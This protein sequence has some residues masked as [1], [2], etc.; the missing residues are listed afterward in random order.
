[1]SARK[2]ETAGDGFHSDGQCLFLKV[3]DGGRR[4]SWVYRFVR[5]GKAT[6]MGLGPVSAVSLKEAR[7]KRDEL[8]KMVMMGL[9]PLDE[10]RKNIEARASRKTFGDAAQAYIAQ[11]KRDWSASS[12]W[13]WTNLVTRKELS[14]FVKLPVDEIGLDDVK[15]PVMAMADGGAVSTA[16]MAQS[17]IHAVLDFAVEHGWRSEDRRSSWSPIIRRPKGERPHHP[18]L[19]WPEAPAALAA[20][21]ESGGVSARVLEFVILTATRLTEASE[22][23]WQEID[24]AAKTWTVPG[25]RTKTRQP[26]VVPLSARALEI[27]NECAAHRANDWLFFGRRDSRP[28]SRVSI[29]GQCKRSTGASVHGF[30]AT[31]RSWCADHA[32]E[33][34]LAESALS[35][36]AGGVVAAYQRSSLLE[37]RRPLMERWA[38]FLSGEEQ[39][40][41]VVS[42]KAR[43]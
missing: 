27:V 5:G 14:T 17:R 42:F 26:H 8:A 34:E 41:E 36:I 12:L 40:A 43:A 6:V 39:S 25:S 9:N 3:A 16:R 13:Q 1:L 7:R 31:F 29:W 37:R 22:A 18:M 21:R 4:K 11:R 32:V 30:R 15:R 28:L 35:H 24:L 10:R 2:V 33:F 19:A 20:L 38:A 23:R